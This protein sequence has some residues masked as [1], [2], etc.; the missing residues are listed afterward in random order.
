MQINNYFVELINNE[1]KDL[2]A[3]VMDQNG[4]LVG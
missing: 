3:L 4:K 2:N 1:V